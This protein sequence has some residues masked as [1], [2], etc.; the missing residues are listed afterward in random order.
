L[1]A[2][3]LRS[4]ISSAF[5]GSFPPFHSLYFH[6][7]CMNLYEPVYT[8]GSATFC[9]ESVVFSAVS[10]NALFILSNMLPI[11]VDTR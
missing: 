8:S 7:H 6:L 5:I 11:L 2:V 4:A 9:A 3:G 1:T 10:L